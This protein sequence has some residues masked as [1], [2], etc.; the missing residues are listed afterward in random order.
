M[1]HLIMLAFFGAL[2]LQQERSVAGV[3]GL[4]ERRAPFCSRL[5]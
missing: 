5:S 4:S 1:I 2:L 3:I